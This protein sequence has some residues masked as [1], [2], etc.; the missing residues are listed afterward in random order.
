M[1]PGYDTSSSLRITETGK[2]NIYTFCKQS[3][4]EERNVEL[5]STKK[6]VKTHAITKE[7][8]NIYP[9]KK[10]VSTRANPQDYFR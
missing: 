8:G 10:A 5:S 4:R 3:N 1:F 9:T 2:I 6:I 7:G